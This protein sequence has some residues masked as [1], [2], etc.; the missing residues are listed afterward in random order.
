[1]SPRFNP[2]D[3]IEGDVGNHHGLQLEVIDQYGTEPRYVLKPHN[4]N[5]K[6][7]IWTRDKRK[8]GHWDDPHDLTYSEAAE[9]ID[10]AFTLA[11]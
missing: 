3:V 6:L 9:R 8:L 4:F 7:A 5:A 1:M 10:E 11:P 2:G